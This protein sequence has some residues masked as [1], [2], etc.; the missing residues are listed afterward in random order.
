MRDLDHTVTLYG[1]G[2]SPEG[3]D[4]W[5]VRPAVRQGYGTGCGRVRQ[6]SRGAR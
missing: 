3:V 5:L 1:Y 6:C 2:T 4:F